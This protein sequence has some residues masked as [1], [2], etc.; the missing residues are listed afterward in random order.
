MRTPKRYMV[1][2]TPEGRRV[3]RNYILSAGGFAV[4]VSILMWT[5]FGEWRWFVTGL[6]LFIIAAIAASLVRD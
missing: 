1:E 5:W 3:L 2:S 4:P 6:A